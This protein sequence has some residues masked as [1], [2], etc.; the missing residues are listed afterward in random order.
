MEMPVLMLVL[1]QITAR[2]GPWSLVADGCFSK[3]IHLVTGDVG[4]GKSTLALI[5][6]GLFPPEKGT[7]HRERIQTVML[8]AQFPEFHLTG[9]TVGEE[10]AS[11]GLDAEKVIRSAGLYITAATQSLCLSRGELKRLHL[12]CALGRP[13]DLLLL[14]EPFSSL[15]CSE[16]ERLCTELS[17]QQG[18]ITV[19]FTHEQ[20]TFP[21][22]DRIWEIV[23]GRLTD[24]GDLPGAL[25]RWRHA[26]SLIKKLVRA[27]TVPENLT[28]DNI[29]EAACRIR[30]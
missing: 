28:P 30:E 4:S 7:V 18:G 10:C 27:G 11:W 2:H 23:D 19:I 21:R 5:M 12:A 6:A 9:L 1:D 13:Y 25:E 22:V 8:S 29:R 16:K 24:C 14:D 26:P 3:G 20:V 17:R 15:D